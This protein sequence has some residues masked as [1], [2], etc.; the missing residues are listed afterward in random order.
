MII[1]KK[2]IELQ[3]KPQL[4]INKN[5]REI[6]D[7]AHNSIGAT[8][9]SGYVI[10]KPTGSIANKDLCMD[11]VDIHF[12]DI[13]EPAYTEFSANVDILDLFEKYPELETGELAFGLV[14]TH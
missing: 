5:I 12:M 10:F 9:W 7:Y 13:G 3:W 8:E 1:Q 14:H 11:V 6:I 2:E 4:Q